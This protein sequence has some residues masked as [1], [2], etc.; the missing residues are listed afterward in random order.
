M[1]AMVL[2]GIALLGV[3]LYQTDLGEV[4]AHLRQVPVWG[5]GLLF[6][7]YFVGVAAE[8]AS[9]QLTLP[10]LPPTPRWWYRFWKV[11]MAGIGLENVTPLG[12]LG[13]EPIKAIVMKRYYG[14]PYRDASASLV[15]TRTTDVIG[16]LVFIAL[17]LALML[18]AKLLPLSY[19]AGAVAG[20]VFLAV[21]VALFVWVQRGRAFSRV[22]H[23]LEHGRLGGPLRRA[24]RR[25]PRRGA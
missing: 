18:H 25:R 13:G 15:L 24:G 7:V 5:L 2:V 19:R 20:L 4:W 12:G 22:R 6:V 23:W 9:W 3:I 17:G 11:A 8:A 10:S 14:V 16:L 21:C 1:L